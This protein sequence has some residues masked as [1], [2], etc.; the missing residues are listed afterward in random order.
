MKLNKLLRKINNYND[1]DLAFVYIATFK[2]S[3]TNNILYVMSVADAMKVCSD[4]R[5]QGRGQYGYWML[6]W[7]LVERLQ[8]EADSYTPEIIRKDDGRFANLFNELGV[9]DL[10]KQYLR[11]CLTAQQKNKNKFENKC[12]GNQ[13]KLFE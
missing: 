7:T 12:V 9:E 6:C 2:A 13:Q 11:T 3:S 1:K 8:H 4:P 5:T 10:S